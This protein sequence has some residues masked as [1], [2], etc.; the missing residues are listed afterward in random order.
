M[1]SSK[2]IIAIVVLLAGAGIMGALVHKRPAPKRAKQ[3]DPGALVHVLQVE[4]KRHQTR[5]TATGT[6]QAAGEVTIIPQVSGRVSHVATSFVAGGFFKAGELLFQIED[7]DYLLAVEHARA[8]LAGAQYEISVAESKARVARSEWE[9][10]G[11][12]KTGNVNPLVLH[13][14]Q[15]EHARAALASATASLKQAELDL[16]R[17]KISAPFNCLVRSESVEPGQYV[18]A[19]TG[20]S[21]VAGTDMVEI[22]VPLPQDDLRWIEIPRQANGGTGSAS[23][24]KMKVGERVFEWRGNII[25]S[26]R[27]V[28]PKSRMVN[29]VVAVRDPYGLKGSNA[30]AL[31][32]GAF[33][34][35]VLLGKTLPGAVS[36]PRTALRE[37]STVWVMDGENKLRFRRVSP[38]KT[39]REHVL[40][41]EGLNEKD[42][43]VLTTL[44]GAADG[45]KLRAA[46]EG[47]TE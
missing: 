27:E 1:K 6:V 34:E 21:V 2:W 41:G 45:M 15:L 18:R 8:K 42:L 20:V 43:V 46:A 13:E 16:A 39:E 12:K 38:L 29:I 11:D 10:V 4:K 7:S 22:I 26:L 37:D 14:P 28:D 23:I 31:P 3:P 36:I 17:T 5:V 30:A 44:S 40:I 32:M 47:N 25:R 19:G 9:R 33:V 24:V 35:V